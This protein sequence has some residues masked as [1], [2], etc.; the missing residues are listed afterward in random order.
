MY[1]FEYIYIDEKTCDTHT[2]P[3]TCTIITVCSVSSVEFQSL[4]LCIAFVDFCS[5]NE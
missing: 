4:K 3:Y 2:H 1:M 5:F